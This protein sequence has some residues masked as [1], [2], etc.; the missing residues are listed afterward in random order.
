MSGAG[1]LAF[2]P[3]RLSSEPFKFL[4]PRN[5]KKHVA[6]HFRI[7]IRTARDWLVDGV[8]ADR[9]LE[10]AVVIERELDRLAAEIRR[11]RG[12]EE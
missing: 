6:R 3:A 8:P 11:L 4:W 9:R 12:A 7:G 1:A 10:R 5:T 2:R